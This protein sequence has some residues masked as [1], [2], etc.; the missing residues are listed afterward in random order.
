MLRS[1]PDARS[2][3]IVEASSGSTVFSL[4]ILAR[5]L[6]NHNDVHAYVTNKKHP[7]SLRLL[8]FFGLKT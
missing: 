2:K 1:D 3:T 5:A 4:A 6:W 8:K 7:D